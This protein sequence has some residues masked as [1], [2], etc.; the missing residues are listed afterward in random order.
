[1]ATTESQQ[2]FS[3]AVGEWIQSLMNTQ[4]EDFKTLIEVFGAAVRDTAL[5]KSTVRKS[6]PVLLP[7]NDSCIAFRIFMSH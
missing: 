1:M 3:N 5:A 4:N 6:N 7:I 2:E